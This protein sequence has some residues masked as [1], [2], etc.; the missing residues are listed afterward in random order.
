MHKNQINTFPCDISTFTDLAFNF[1]LSLAV[2]DV[3]QPRGQT[4][5]LYAHN[6]SACERCLTGHNFNDTIQNVFLHL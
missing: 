5:P 6:T 3:S 2:N 1:K 4:P